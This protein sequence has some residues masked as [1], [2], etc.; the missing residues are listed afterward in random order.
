MHP[1]FSVATIGVLAIKYTSF[2]SYCFFCLQP[3]NVNATTAKIKTV[4]IPNA[5]EAAEWQEFSFT[6]GENIKWYGHLE[7]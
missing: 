6:A 5:G 7:R 2:V 4:T 3:V 1:S